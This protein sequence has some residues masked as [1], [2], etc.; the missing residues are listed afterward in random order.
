MKSK[1][2]SFLK[3]ISIIKRNTNKY[4]DTKLSKYNIGGG[5]QF[6]LVRVYENPN[7]TMYDLARLGQFD[8]ATVTKAVHKLIN[9]GYLSQET[10]EKDK[11]LKRLNITDKAM[12]VLEYIYEIKQ[13]WLKNLT[14]GISQAE[15]EVLY[16]QLEMIASNSKEHMK[17]IMEMKEREVCGK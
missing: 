14:E 11:R 12:P 15:A 6:F 16:K 9:E 5:Q 8:K 17:D 1:S 3:Y 10:D 7:I 13:Q 4:F 2:S